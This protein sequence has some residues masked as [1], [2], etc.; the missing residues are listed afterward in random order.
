MSRQNRL[1]LISIKVSNFLTIIDAMGSAITVIT[2]VKDDID[3]LKAT[4][5][6][7]LSQ[8]YFDF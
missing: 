4:A 8:K 7:I 3:G 5:A 2:V 1:V 6:S